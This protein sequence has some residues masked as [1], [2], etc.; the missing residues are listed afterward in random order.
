MKNETFTY[1]SVFRKAKKVEINQLK[2]IL[3]VHPNRKS[4]FINIEFYDK[5]NNKII[6]IPLE[7]NLFADGLLETVCK[8]YNIEIKILT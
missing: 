2:Y 1:Y 3:I 7:F 8:Q 6:K 5:D 4:G